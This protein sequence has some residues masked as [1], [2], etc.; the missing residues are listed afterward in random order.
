MSLLVAA[1]AL[2]GCNAS[3]TFGGLKPGETL[4]QG[5][6]ID[7]QPIDLVPVGSSREQVLLA[8]GTPVDD[9]DLRQRGVLL[10][11]ADAPPRRS[12]S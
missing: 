4:T 9:R 8:L 12:P 7:Q 5:Y 1:I 3:T 6:V 2:S 10:H 11:L